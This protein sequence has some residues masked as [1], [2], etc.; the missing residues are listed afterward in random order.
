MVIE[1][2][3]N[4]SSESL[5]DYML[6]RVQELYEAELPLFTF[7]EEIKGLKEYIVMRRNRIRS[8]AQFKSIKKTSQN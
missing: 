2:E 4:D 8:L 7:E 1:R 3:P 6:T 5:L